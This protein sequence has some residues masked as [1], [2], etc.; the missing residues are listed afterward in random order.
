[1]IGTT[2]MALHATVTLPGGVIK[3][4]GDAGVTVIVL[5]TGTNAL[6]HISVAVHVSVIVPPHKP[7]FAVKVD[8]FDVPAMRQPPI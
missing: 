5:E 2:G 4:A 3:T 6:P 1:M 7:G 8:G